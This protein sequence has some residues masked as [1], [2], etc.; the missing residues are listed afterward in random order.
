M[1]L[2][3]YWISTILAAGLLFIGG[4]LFIMQGEHQIEEMKHLG[5]PV[6]ILTL[7]GI[8][9]ILG[10]VAIVIPRFPRLKEWAYAGFVI[11]LIA[12]SASHAYS[13]DSLV[14]IASPLIF[15]LLII[16]SWALRPPSRKLKAQ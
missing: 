16:V 14:Q 6:Y 12:A 15:L 10:S 1:K 3:P 2:S 11:D 4:I 8:G 13:G 5:Y 7:L 9:R